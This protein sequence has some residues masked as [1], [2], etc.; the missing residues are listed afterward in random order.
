MEQTKDDHSGS[1]AL[2]PYHTSS[3]RGYYFELKVVTVL[4]H[5]KETK[6]IE[7]T[8]RLPK[9]SDKF[10][11]FS[12]LQIQPTYS[13]DQI[14]QLPEIPIEAVDIEFEILTEDNDSDAADNFFARLLQP[15]LDDN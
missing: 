9:I 15:V 11:V 14:E 12:T 2:A 10:D 7:L 5:K 8:Y 1:L 6:N 3:A 4:N 13:L